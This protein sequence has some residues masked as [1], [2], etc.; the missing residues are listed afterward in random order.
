MVLS[1]R[2]LVHVCINFPFIQTCKGDRGQLGTSDI[3]WHCY[4]SLLAFLSNDGPGP[5]SSCSL[6]S[7]SIEMVDTVDMGLPWLSGESRQ[8]LSFSDT[9]SLLVK[10]RSQVLALTSFNG[11][12]CYGSISQISTSLLKFLWSWCFITA[13]VILTKTEGDHRPLLDVHPI[14]ER[15]M[16][17]F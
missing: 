3:A 5:C 17:W 2:A 16:G 13:S 11:E 7:A 10:R 9:V 1:N 12:Q 15:E 14:G 8:K 6:I 4:S